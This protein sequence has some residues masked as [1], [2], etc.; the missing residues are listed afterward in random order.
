[1]AQASPGA[2]DEPR[3]RALNVVLVAADLKSSLAQQIGQD[4]VAILVDHRQV[5][6]HPFGAVS[7][8]GCREPARGLVEPVAQLGHR[9]RRAVLAAQPDLERRAFAL[10]CS[11]TCSALLLQ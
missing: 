9:Q 7:T 4:F 1:M 2:R 6:R 5:D 8:I 3:V 11:A 10:I